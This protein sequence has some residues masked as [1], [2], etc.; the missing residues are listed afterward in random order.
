MHR[1]R[2]R[3]QTHINLVEIFSSRRFFFLQSV[4]STLFVLVPCAYICYHVWGRE[5]IGRHSEMIHNNQHLIEV[6]LFCRRLKGLLHDFAEFKQPV[7]CISMPQI[8]RSLR[9]PRKSR[10]RRA[11]SIDTH[12][13]YQFVFFIETK[14]KP[15]SVH[16]PEAEH[17]LCS[18]PPKMIDG[19]IY[20]VY[21]FTDPKALT[22]QAIIDV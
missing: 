5:N 13:P 22:R 9:I 14:L 19:H 17:R 6:I 16:R 2:L 12:A 21:N 20:F 8:H 7:C 10:Q 11:S 1:V 4:L 18:R 15:P 3:T